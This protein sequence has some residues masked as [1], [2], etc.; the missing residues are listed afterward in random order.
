MQR[1]IATSPNAITGLF[2]QEKN[3]KKRTHFK[4]KHFSFTANITFFN[5]S[6]QSEEW[7]TVISATITM[8]S[9]RLLQMALTSSK[10]RDTI[11]TRHK[12]FPL[13]KEGSPFLEHPRTSHCQCTGPCAAWA[14]MNW[15]QPISKG[16]YYRPLP[17]FIWIYCWDNAPCSCQVT[18]ITFF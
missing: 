8:P 10:K 1:V 13:K 4:S 5:L 16:N 18:L 12:E 15:P 7:T 14:R 3:K 11:F 9:F 2:W 17:Q 6:L